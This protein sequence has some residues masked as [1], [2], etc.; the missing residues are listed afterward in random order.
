[1][2]P[3]ASQPASALQRGIED[4]WE[5]RADLAPEEIG[6]AVKPAVEQALLGLESGELRV[7]EPK[8]GGGSV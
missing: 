8:A 5:R 7:A 2:T 6:D 1:M 3:A 4:A